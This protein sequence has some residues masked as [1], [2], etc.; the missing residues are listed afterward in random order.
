MKAQVEVTICERP[1]EDVFTLE[2]EMA[3]IIE[4]VGFEKGEV[5]EIG[6]LV[7]PETEITDQAELECDLRQDF[8]QVGAVA[9]QVA[10]VEFPLG[11]NSVKL[12]CMTT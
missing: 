4:K 9:G 7:F 6:K 8:S 1:G 10:T 5:G 2:L 3:Q 11:L 12:R